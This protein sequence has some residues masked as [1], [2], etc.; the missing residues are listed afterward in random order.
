MKNLLIYIN[1]TKQF[2]SFY[3]YEPLVKIQI[4][5][6]LRYWKPEDIMLVTN[7]PYEYMGIKSIVVD[8]SLYCE[9]RKR[10]SKINVI[11]HLIETGQIKELCWFHDFDAYQ[12]DNFDESVIDG[13]DAGFTDYGFN[14]G[15]NTGSFFFKPEALP[16]FE[17]IQKVMNEQKINEEQA[18]DWLTDNDL[19]KKYTRLNSTYN[20]GRKHKASYVYSIS[21]KPIKVFHFHPTITGKDLFDNVKT[22]IPTE[23]LKSFNDNGFI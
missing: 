14:K 22:L 20:L 23:L 17:S 1:P 21:L 19:I 8:D 15:W 11:C 5:N 16:I 18:L 13:F 4:E 10:A 9:H 2:I 12:T 3:D 6:S 7:F